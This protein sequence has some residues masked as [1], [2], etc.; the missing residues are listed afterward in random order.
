MEY[1]LTEGQ[2][3]GPAEIPAVNGL[4]TRLG[5]AL[6]ESYIEFLKAHD[7]GEGFIGDSYIIFWK[8]EQLV[9]FNRE[10]ESRHMRQVYFC[11]LLT[12]E[13]RGMG[14]THWMQ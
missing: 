13:A 12:A 11:S 3:N 2:L 7:G 14:L 4:S 8:A 1:H 6:P 10:Y 9:E 5:V